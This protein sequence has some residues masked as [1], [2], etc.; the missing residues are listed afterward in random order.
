MG[1]R[2]KR[3]DEEEQQGGSGSVSWTQAVMVGGLAMSIPFL[4]FAPAGL[5][6]WI[7]QHYGTEPWFT[8]GGFVFGLLG[9]AWDVYQMLKKIG[10]LK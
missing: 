5:G 1:D 7:D 4:L 2:R 9:T 10:M 6:Y 8:I 3:R